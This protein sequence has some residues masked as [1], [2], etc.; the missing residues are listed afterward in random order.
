RAKNAQSFTY[1]DEEST[2]S[3]K[4]ALLCSL[5]F[6]ACG[7]FGTANAIEPHREE[8]AAIQHVQAAND[9]MASQDFAKAVAELEQAVVLVPNDAQYRLKLSNAYVALRQYQPA[10]L[11]LRQAATLAPGDEQISNLFSRFWNM[12]D[13]KGVFNVGESVE[14]V[15]ALLG[16]PDQR[17]K[18]GDRDRLVY[19]FYSVDAKQGK[20]HELLDLRGLKTQHLI[21]TEIVRVDLDGRA[22]RVNYRV[23]NQ[24]V[25]TA[26]HVL[27]NEEIQNWSELVNIQ[28]LHGQ[29]TT[30]LSL[31][32]VVEGMMDT[33]KKSN[34]DRQFRILEQDENT[35][36]YEWKTGGSENSVAQ[37]EIVKLLYGPRDMHRLAYVKKC[38]G[39]SEE[40]RT[41]WL[42]IIKSAKL[43]SVQT[44][45]QTAK[46]DKAEKPHAGAVT[47]NLV[48]Q[49]G[50][51]LSGAAIIQSQGAS[52]AK[53]QSTFQQ[54]AQVADKLG[55][56][57]DELPETGEDT[58]Q[59]SIAA[60]NYLMAK[61]G[62]RIHR[63]L[64]ANYDHSH[65]A[66]LETAIKSNMLILL[67]A[68]NDSTG[69]A[70][71]QALQDRIKDAKLPE[72]LFQTLLT[73][74]ENGAE[75]K[76]IVMNVLKLHTDIKL[77][78]EKQAKAANTQNERATTSEERVS[79]A[80]QQLQGIWKSVRVD[81]KKEL[82]LPAAGESLLVIENNR[83][84]FVAK[85]QETIAA[86]F[87]ID[88]T[89]SPMRII[90]IY[91]EDGEA[92]RV[93]EI[94]KFEGDTVVLCGDSED[95]VPSEFE[96]PSGS[97]RVL[98]VYKKL[99]G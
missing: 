8:T 60:A 68:P 81:A 42:G 18:I 11:S 51:R 70:L 57:L 65:A 36:V 69:K 61:T 86:T 20:V 90:W 46:S 93:T 89:T 71:G 98:T 39:L 24:L 19:G 54:A 95:Q 33:L 82:G 52:P 77:L 73:N 67:Y 85:N 14:D 2:M 10:W 12:F 55:I 3:I 9:A 26:E 17:V 92:D 37:H 94:M 76:L 40:E 21:P 45:T 58:I 48:W 6:A 35:I 7:W 96:V 30:G 78:L 56:K 15:V 83:V 47:R 84:S 34:P 99:Q 1:S 43:K 29:A 53:A 25:A 28:R 59:N 88:A 79:K 91:D 72:M 23:N 5:M 4:R 22:W 13:K 27:P 74:I 66:L 62:R 87:E 44:G 32:E 64:S 49:L 75:R 16:K 50:G 38:N 80:T 41:K 97:D 31:E 63:E